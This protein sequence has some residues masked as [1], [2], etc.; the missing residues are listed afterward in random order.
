MDFRLQA[1]AQKKST[2]LFQR[3]RIRS[4]LDQEL[5]TIWRDILFVFQY[6]QI[7]T[8]GCFQNEPEHLLVL[9]HNRQTGN[10]TQ[11]IPKLSL[12]N[13]LRTVVIDKE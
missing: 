4:Q 5:S 8:L 6:N 10:H 11:R 12:Q 3:Q 7:E 1:I 9:C 13:Y 2:L